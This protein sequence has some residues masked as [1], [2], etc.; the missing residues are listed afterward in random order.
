VKVNEK[1]E[2]LGHVVGAGAVSQG[3]EKLEPKRFP[4][5]GRFKFTVGDRGSRVKPW[6]VLRKVRH[7]SIRTG[8]G[9]GVS[10]GLRTERGHKKRY[11]GGPDNGGRKWQGTHKGRWRV[12]SG[13]HKN[14][15][16]LMKSP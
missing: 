12:V 1:S 14:Q 13:V 5:G 8:S 3:R 7:T 11:L 9:G 16:E 2:K 15:K 4:W 6:A 10:R